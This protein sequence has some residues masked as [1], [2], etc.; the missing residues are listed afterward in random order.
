M[1]TQQLADDARAFLE[2]YAREFDSIDGSRVAAL[3]HAP[4]VTMRGDLNLQYAA[5]G[6]SKMC[7]WGRG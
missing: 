5:R 7:G 4:C 2:H 3:Y 1:G 6:N